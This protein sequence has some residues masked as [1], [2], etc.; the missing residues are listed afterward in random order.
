MVRSKRWKPEEE[1]GP[2][3]QAKRHL[4]GVTDASARSTSLFSLCFLP[5]YLHALLLSQDLSF[6]M[7]H[8]PRAG[9]S[10]FPALIGLED[11]KK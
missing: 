6:L 2:Q 7:K 1:K 9:K 11:G 8:H 4:L 3:S 5:W 10:E